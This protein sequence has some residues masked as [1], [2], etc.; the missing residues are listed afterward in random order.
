VRA[1]VIR[2]PETQ[3]QYSW[4]IAVWTPVF[5]QFLHDYLANDKSLAAT[6]PELSVG[7]VIEAAVSAGLG[8]EG[9]PVSGEPYLDI[10]SSE[11]LAKATKRFASAV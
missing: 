5:T 2:P 11:G 3:L 1:I 8:V 7:H 4:A 9:L 6:Q 10:G